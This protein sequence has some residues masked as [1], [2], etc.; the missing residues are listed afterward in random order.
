MG[1][2]SDLVGRFHQ[3]R[4]SELVKRTPGASQA[5]ARW[6]RATQSKLFWNALGALP[7]PLVEESQTDSVGRVRIPT[8]EAIH[9]RDES[10]IAAGDL[11]REEMA[12]WCSTSKFDSLGYQDVYAQVLAHMRPEVGRLLEIGIGIN[13]PTVPSGMHAGH[14]PGASLRGWSHYLP[15]FEIHGADIDE[16]ALVDTDL[17]TTHKVDQRQ[18]GTLAAL[19][20][21]LGS[22]LHVVIDDGLHTPEA[23]ANCVAAFLPLLSPSGI[24]VVED[25]LPEFD[26]L[27]EELPSKLSSDYA[28]AFYPSRI[29]RQ[30][31][32]VGSECGLAVFYRRR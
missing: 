28:V 30:H 21:E 5:A 20:L 4:V 12:A 32:R 8:L 2:S 16:R 10:V 24:M 15:F 25:I 29:L 22:P 26:F 7:P 17:Y 6:W 14:L 27:W 19:A 23:N 13:D 3:T 18:P 31:R 1:L 11:L 9:L